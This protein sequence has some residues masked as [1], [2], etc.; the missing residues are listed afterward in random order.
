M[1]FCRMMFY[2]DYISDEQLVKAVQNSSLLDKCYIGLYEKNW[3]GTKHNNINTKLL[4]N[5]N[6]N[7]EIVYITD[8]IL[9]ISGKE[10]PNIIETHC[11]NY[12]LEKSKQNKY[13]FLIV[14]DT[15]EFLIS[16]DY[17]FMMNEY[18]P[19]MIQ[20]GYD[21][22]AIRLKNFWKNWKTI[23]VNEKE[24]IENWPGEWATFGLVLNPS[25]RFTNIRD[26]TFEN[27]CGVQQE[28]F[29]FHGSFVH[30]DDNLLQKINTWGHSNDIDFKKWYQEKW[31]DWTP[32]T[33]DLHPS[34]RPEIWK[35]AVPYDGP[36][37][38]E[39]Y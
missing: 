9:G 34:T 19:T 13:D 25:M 7:T 8:E 12:I 18:I 11:R 38:K 1:K 35:Q 37:P 26:H 3:S 36:L 15:D 14:Q 28:S 4:Y 6:E 2:S 10:P 24:V 23:L 20:Q 16:E 21:S 30:N 5:L 27:K 31:L 32:E 29:L 17:Q 33:T 22:C 39:C